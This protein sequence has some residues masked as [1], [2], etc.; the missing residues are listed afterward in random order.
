MSKDIEKFL[1]QTEY[2]KLKILPNCVIFMM[3][4]R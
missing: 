1:A 2:N 3:S 4:Q